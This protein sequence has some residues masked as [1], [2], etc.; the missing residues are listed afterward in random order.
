MTDTMTH[1]AP[2]IV[3]QQSETTD[4]RI[5]VVR[6]LQRNP[7]G[8]T[9]KQVAAKLGWPP[10]RASAHLS[11][12]V[13]YAVIDREMLPKPYGLGTNTYLYRA[14]PEKVKVE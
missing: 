2:A 11:R 5:K 7:N 12:L 14:K 9:S 8:M 6:L 13:S 10:G 4:K 1:D 3:P